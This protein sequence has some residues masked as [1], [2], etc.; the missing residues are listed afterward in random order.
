M[1]RYPQLTNEAVAMLLLVVLWSHAAGQQE[2][3]SNQSSSAGTTSGQP[4]AKR[5]TFSKAFV[6]DDRLSALR[7]EPGLQSEVI[8]RLRLGRP[9][10]IIGSARP[11]AESRFCRGADSRRSRGWVLESSLPT[12]G[13]TRDDPRI[14]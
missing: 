3:K 8:H 5:L 6:V 13:K 7:R 14:I 12:P 1:N 10:Y 11:R 2:S 9:V 4:A